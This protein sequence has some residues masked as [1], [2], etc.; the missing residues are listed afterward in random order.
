MTALRAGFVYFLLVF[1]LGL[2]L[3]TVRTMLVGA[4]L[5][6]A[7][8]VW[9]EIPIILAFAWWAA[10]WCAE[11]FGVAIALAS[12]LIMGLS[13]FS[14]LQAGELVVGLVL[15]GQT[16]QSH[17]AALTTGSGAAELLP[18]LLAALFPLISAKLTGR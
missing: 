18:Q 3:G 5:S 12:R 2:A 10:G 6:R 17:L 4:G 9:I 15:M 14:L 7:L 8:L 16:A 1:G 11:R 13:M